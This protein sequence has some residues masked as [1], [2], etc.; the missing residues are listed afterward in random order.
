MG[1]ERGALKCSGPQYA[2]ALSLFEVTN[3]DFQRLEFMD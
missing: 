2:P 3:Q 1:D